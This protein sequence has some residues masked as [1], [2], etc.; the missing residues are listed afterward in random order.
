MPEGNEQSFKC[1]SKYRHILYEIQ[2]IT[3][4]KVN[5]VFIDLLKEQTQLWNPPILPIG[6]Y[7]YTILIGSDIYVNGWSNRKV[8]E[9]EEDDE[10]E[11]RMKMLKKKK[12][13]SGR[14]WL[15]NKTK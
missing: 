14:K 8:V 2:P 3:I 6:V 9:E 1:S 13:R 15:W 5:R 11:R 12:D 4:K 10:E 7:I